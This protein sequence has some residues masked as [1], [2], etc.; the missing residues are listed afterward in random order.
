VIEA[1]ACAE[2]PFVLEAEAELL[3]VPHVAVVVGEVM[4]TCL[5]EPAARSPKLHVRTPLAIEHPLSE[6]AASIVQF[7]PLVVGSVSVTVTLV[8]VPAPA[9]FVTVMTKPIVLPALTV[10]WS[11][12]LVRLR[13]GARTVT[14]SFVVTVDWP[15]A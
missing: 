1:E 15:S 13:F 4:W 14:H 12:T 9:A 6:P 8:A 7:R 5:L 2:P 10:P 11:A 3:T